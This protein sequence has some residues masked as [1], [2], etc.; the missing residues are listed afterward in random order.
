MLID[1]CPGLGL[2]LEPAAM[3]LT[4]LRGRGDVRAS[5]AGPWPCSVSHVLKR[6]E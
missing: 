1:K 3:P 4:Y 2:R 5:A 6:I